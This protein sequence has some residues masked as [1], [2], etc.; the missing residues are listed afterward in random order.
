MKLQDNLNG[1]NLGTSEIQE[2]SEKLAL[3]SRGVEK[4]YKEMINSGNYEFVEPNWLVQVGSVPNDAKY[5]SG[6]LWGLKK[7]NEK[8]GMIGA[9]LEEA[10][11]ITTGSNE[12][13][14][15]VI[16]S[17]IRYTHQDLKANMWKN[18]MKL[19][20]MEWMTMRTDT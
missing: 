6:M 11:K 5:T 7:S 18:P 10:W 3:K 19:L 2:L 16:D 12:I 1:Q 8:S 17:G 13:K 4:Q 20:V 14:V 9:N 15:A